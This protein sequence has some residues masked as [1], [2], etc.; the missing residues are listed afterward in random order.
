MIQ[1]QDEQYD[2]VIFCLENQFEFRRDVIAGH[3]QFHHFL[4]DFG[5]EYKQYGI[6]GRYVDFVS[7]E[8]EHVAE[9]QWVHNV[10]FYL[11]AWK[12]KLERLRGEPDCRQ[13]CDEAE[14][15]I[16]KFSNM[17]QVEDDYI[18]YIYRK[19]RT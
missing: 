12:C 17:P 6:T 18:S 10:N 4:T 3:A 5:G 8:M 19:N 7:Y 15:F 2:H 1:K 11:D 16:K 9:N 14:R 13:E